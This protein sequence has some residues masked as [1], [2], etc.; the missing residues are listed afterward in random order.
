MRSKDALNL[1][2]TAQYPPYQ[3]SKQYR[4]VDGQFDPVY[5]NF[6]S[7]FR[8]IE[9]KIAV[10]GSGLLYDNEKAEPVSFLST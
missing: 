4:A 1:F 5:E 6:Y 3:L 2:K 7:T 9:S 8:S 10:K